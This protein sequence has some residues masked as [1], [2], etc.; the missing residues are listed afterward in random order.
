MN[1]KIYFITGTSQGLGYEM[2][3]YFLDKGHIVVGT[4]RDI[5]KLNISL[6]SNSTFAH[7]TKLFF[8]IKP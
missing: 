7:K 8:S 6:L 3:K 5:N 1:P 2:A 4:T